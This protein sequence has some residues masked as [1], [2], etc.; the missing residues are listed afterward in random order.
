[1]HAGDAD[2]A[3]SNKYFFPPYQKKKKK[4][5]CISLLCFLFPRKSYR[6]IPQRYPHLNFPR[7]CSTF[8]K[9][10]SYSSSSS[11]VCADDYNFHLHSFDPHS[12]YGALIDNSSHKRHLG[13]IHALLLV[14][15]LQESRFLINSVRN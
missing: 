13:Q 8:L 12:F 1:M 15:R 10:F 4:E 2:A 7:S 9:Q 14:S 5:K 6:W 3:C 11:P